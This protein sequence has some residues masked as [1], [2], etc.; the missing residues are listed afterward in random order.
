MTTTRQLLS[1]TAA[2]PVG[3]SVIAVVGDQFT[4]R[5]QR[6]GGMRRGPGGENDDD[7]YPEHRRA[8]R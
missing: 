7:I 1:D 3:E 6:P 2:E 4:T 8:A 5:N